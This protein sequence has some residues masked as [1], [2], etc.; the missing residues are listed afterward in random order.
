[1]K[2]I[3]TIALTSLLINSVFAE[4]AKEASVAKG[5]T[6]LLSY[7][8]P[9]LNFLKHHEFKP[10]DASIVDISYDK[11]ALKDLGINE[12]QFLRH[13]DEFIKTSLEYLEYKDVAGPMLISFS[14]K[15]VPPKQN[16]KCSETPKKCSLN[17][18]DIVLD[19]QYKDINQNIA[20]YIIK[21]LDKAAQGVTDITK[22]YSEPIIS[23]FEYIGAMRA[24]ILV[25]L[26]SADKMTSRDEKLLK[27]LQKT[28]PDFIYPH[29]EENA[30]KF[31][32]LQEKY[33][34]IN[35]KSNNQSGLLKEQDFKGAIKPDNT[36]EGNEL[37]QEKQ[38]KNNNEAANDTLN[39]E[40]T[41]EITD[42][43]KIIMEFNQ[44]R[45]ELFPMPE[46]KSFNS[47]KNN[48]I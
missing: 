8:Q 2:K 45:Q 44:K 18:I 15:A 39:N 3:F 10:S 16:I 35:N 20:P 42:E 40:I 46:P 27:Q 29:G 11:Y 47:E 23:N 33:W 19:T 7:E 43:Q 30:K 21:Q 6:E 31:S 9:T 36:I 5:F 17:S 14:L 4:E 12:K 32:E 25:N 26:T 48:E 37:I 34:M 24:F 13:I 1:M 38:D 41:D 28:I 22:D